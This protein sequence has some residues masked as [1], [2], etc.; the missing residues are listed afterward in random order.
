MSWLSLVFNPVA[1]FLPPPFI[2]ALNHVAVILQV[3]NA[4]NK[5]VAPF[6]TI[7]GMI[8]KLWLFLPRGWGAESPLNI[9]FK[10]AYNI[11]DAFYCFNFCA[12]LG[13]GYRERDSTYW[14]AAVTLYIFEWLAPIWFL[15]LY[16]AHI[17]LHGYCLSHG[18][19]HTL[20]N[21]FDW[22]ARLCERTHLRHCL[23]VGT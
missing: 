20:S 21:S 23:R 11:L 1:I 3:N 18:S 7:V 8:F 16:L 13:C 4:L 6:I 15:S 17:W 12:P 22:P 10:H 14:W 5:Q 19:G 2:G 9:I